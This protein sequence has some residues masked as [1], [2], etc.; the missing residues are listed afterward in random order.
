MFTS[1]YA[2]HATDRNAVAISVKPPDWYCGVTYPILAP[3]WELVRGIK[4]G[5]MSEAEYTSEYL[6]L[7][8]KRGASPY[9]TL[10]DLGEQAI[11]LCYE[12]PEDF[13]HRHIVALWIEQELKIEVPEISLI[14]RPTLVDEIFTF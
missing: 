11:L 3:S 9:R 7:I 4:S 10:A 5:Q 2:K 6:K 14:K 12:K 8:K 1:Y 13:C